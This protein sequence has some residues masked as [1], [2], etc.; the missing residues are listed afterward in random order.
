M[1]NGTKVSKMELNH[2]E[3]AKQLADLDARLKEADKAEEEK[4]FTDIVDE[5]KALGEFFEVINTPIVRLV[6]GI[7]FVLRPI[8]VKDWLS[9]GG[10]NSTVV[11]QF[12]L[13]RN[14]IISPTL[15]EHQY[16]QMPAPISQSLYL[17]LMQNFF[18]IAG[19]VTEN[20]ST[21]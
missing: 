7:E 11:N 3:K 1:N 9:I 4:S 12:K 13:V 19:K 8:S 10:D 20:T 5:T 18:L 15:S 2:V 14:C 21:I 16:N 6:E 17:F